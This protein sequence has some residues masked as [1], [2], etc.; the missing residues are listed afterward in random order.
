LPGGVNG[1]L[2]KD[3]KFN[4]YCSLRINEKKRGINSQVKNFDIPQVAK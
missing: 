1:D 4:E 2:L 3:I